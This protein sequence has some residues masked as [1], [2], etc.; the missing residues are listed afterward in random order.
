M[1]EN[2][3]RDEENYVALFI[4]WDNLALSTAV[5]YP[6][7]VPDV[8]AIVRAAQRFGTILIARAY[9]EWNVSS[10]RL[11]V[12]RAGVEPVYAPTF[13]FEPEQGSQMPRGKSLAD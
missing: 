11:S 9:A 2:M 7:A 13:R 8:R 4:D 5:Y 1:K 10:D 6:G 12:Y 3:P